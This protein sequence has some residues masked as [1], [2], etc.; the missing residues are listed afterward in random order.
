M[1]LLLHHPFCRHRE[2]KTRP[3]TLRLT[4]DISVIR[5]PRWEGI[6]NYV[7]LESSIFCVKIKSMDNTTDKLNLN[8]LWFLSAVKRKRRGGV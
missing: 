6:C 4:S 8:I 5:W 7:F 3:L 2:G 1:S